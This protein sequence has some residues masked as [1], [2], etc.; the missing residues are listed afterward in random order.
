MVSSVSVYNWSGFYVG[1]NVGGA[2]DDGTAT[3]TALDGTFV[4][5]GTTH[6]RPGG[7]QIG[8]N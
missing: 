3:N 6:Q 5:S 2:W 4:S 7:R 1:A 8:Y